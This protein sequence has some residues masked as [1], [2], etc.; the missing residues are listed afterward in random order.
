MLD[1]NKV[2]LR[3]ISG[4]A[5]GSGQARNSNRSFHDRPPRT[6]Q[7]REGAGIPKSK[8]QAIVSSGR[9]A[10]HQICNNYSIGGCEKIFKAGREHLC[11][12][13]CGLRPVTACLGG[14]G[15]PKN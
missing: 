7:G 10:S 12:S 2:H 5:I 6:M 8:S 13:C 11:V 4:S 1:D 9:D 15:T 3:P 14:G